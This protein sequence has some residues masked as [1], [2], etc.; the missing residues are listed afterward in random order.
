MSEHEIAKLP[1]PPISK[2]DETFLADGLEFVWGNE[3][4][5]NELN[6]LF[7]RVGFPQRDP[8]KLQMALHNTYSTIWVRA[9]RKSRLAKQGQLL[10]FARATS[11]GALSA[12]IWDVA[13]HPA[14]QRNGLG[15]A[16]VERLTASLVTDGIATIT[17]YAEPGVVGLYEKLGFVKDPDGVKGLAFQ[18]K[19]GKHLMSAAR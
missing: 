2:S 4:N 12:T 13:V 8:L 9:A 10:G 16:M 17:L 1:P 5:L 14:W 11:D 18:T 15:R 7:H 19:K 6:D 3:V